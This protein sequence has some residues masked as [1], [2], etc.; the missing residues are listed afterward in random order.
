MLFVS[1]I[2]KDDK[3]DD[4]LIMV[5]KAFQKET[6]IFEIEIFFICVLAK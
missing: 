3:D 2:L 1:A 5:S 4:E 6:P